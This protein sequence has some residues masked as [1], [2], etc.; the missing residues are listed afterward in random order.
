MRCPL[1]FRDHIQVQKF[2][3][4]YTYHSV[5]LFMHS[6]VSNNASPVHLDLCHKLGYKINAAVVSYS[7]QKWY[8]SHPLQAIAGFGCLNFELVTFPGAIS[9]HAQTFLIQNTVLRVSLIR[10]G[11][12]THYCN[13]TSQLLVSV[14]CEFVT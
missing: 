4:H 12:A 6:G 13:W 9:V 11:K 10:P 2:E 7:F 3:A 14:Q 8:R 1:G 5:L